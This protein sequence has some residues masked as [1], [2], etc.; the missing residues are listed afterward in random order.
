M[1]NTDAW[2]ADARRVIANP[3][4]IISQALNRLENVTISDPSNPYIHALETSAVNVSA[5]F[6]EQEV[7]TRKQ[8]A[9]MA[10]TPQELYLHM[11]DADYASRFAQPAQTTF[12]LMLG[13]EEIYRRAVAW[14]DTGIRKMVIPRHTVFE[15]AEVEFTMQYPI[16]I[17]I[18]PHGGLQ[19]VYDNDQL[20]PLQNLSTN[21]V[22]WSTVKFDGVE[23]VRIQIQVNQFAV[24]SVKAA[25]SFAK[26]FEAKYPFSDQFHYARAYYTDS[27]GAWIEM[28][29]THTD[30]V[31]DPTKPTCVLRV[32]GSE[33]V[34]RVPQVYLTAQ[35]LTT[36][37][38]VDIYTTQ[39]PVSMVLSDY[40]AN[41]FGARWEDHDRVGADPYAAVIRD[42]N[43]LLIYSD[44]T[45][46]GGSR[47][48]TFE[49]LRERVINNSLGRADV[50]ITSIQLGSRLSDMGY[51]MVVDVDNITNR[52]FL[53]TR[54]LPE[55][56]D[57]ATVS[58]AGATMMT[59]TDTMEN[60]AN[61][62][63]VRDNG[64]RITILPDTLYQNV[65]GL[66]NV[67]PQPTLDSLAA[68]PV[69]VRAR[70]VN[71]NNY[72]Y[73]PFHYVLDMNFDRFE[74]RAYYLDSPRIAGRTFVADN[75]T[76]PISVSTKSVDI[77]RTPDGYA[78][79]LTLA[80]GDF[81]KGLLDT[82]VHV[83]LGFTPMGETGRAYQNGVLAGMTSKGERI[84]TFA[85]NTDYDIT[86]KH[87]LMVDSFQMNQDPIH[88][89]PMSLQPEF[90]I[91][92]SVSDLF[93][94]GYQRNEV[95]DA[96]GMNLLPQ[97]VKAI[98][99]ERLSVELGTAM[100]GLWT[101]SRSIASSQDYRRY[102]AD[103]PAVHEKTV[104]E[105]D[106]LT[107]TI[108]VTFVNGEPQYTILHAA[109]DP[110]LD[111][112][113]N[114]VIRHYAGDVMLDND[115]N[116]VVESTRKMLRQFDLMLIDGVY[117][118]ASDTATV[119]YRAT[120]P[121]IITGWLND[122]IASV[123]E[124]LLEQTNLYFQPKTTIG[125]VNVRV[126]EEKVVSIPSA[127]SF[128]VVYYLSGSAYRNPELR[129]ALTASAAYVINRELQNPVVT[130]SGLTRAMEELV[131]GD[132]IAVSIS[133]L[134]GSTP[135]DAITMMDDSARLSI[136]K[137]AVARADGTIAVEDDISVAFI[138]HTSN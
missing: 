128:S 9:S 114:P 107:G 92:Y 47:G 13:R 123:Q 72:L 119:D 81:W 135:Y 46:N 22:P 132:T 29:T 108:K 31:F 127:Q 25:L 76:V 23:F 61:L 66:I 57:G 91:F 99:R 122:D 93:I 35:M 19:I 102:L 12:T 129:Q 120:I 30:Q 137:K 79:I 15:V 14:G 116:P 65:G 40:S 48:L 68:S 82:Q 32:E 45:V 6:L 97:D 28:L 17:R 7:H 118:F 73:S 52:Q 56:E 130:T 33:L 85:I 110:V 50:P 121:K 60:L 3:S 84:Y 39:G 69:D 43:T 113:G 96:L 64:N 24:R 26:V 109:G 41:Q 104:Y 105:N 21:L 89:Y 74:H 77:M 59:L 8:Y 2:I 103:V 112:G 42:F 62:G 10:L 11:S 55:P 117:W 90:E 18:M 1:S 4:L 94:E 37:L 83:Q 87:G 95:D 54:F 100:E 20:S 134:G 131:S 78:I 106:P 67:V 34:V 115:G 53:A 63:T 138:Q 51:D 86:E 71:E 38:R 5:L 75:E 133:G 27:D 36:E 111:S 49:E 98:V 101:A 80:S 16:E 136:R 70:R 58:G 126:M 44:A 88:R 125:N 124:Y